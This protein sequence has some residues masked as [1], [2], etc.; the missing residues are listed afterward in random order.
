[1]R[2]VGYAES[3]LIVANSVIGALLFAAYM[4]DPVCINYHPD[5]RDVPDVAD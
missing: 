3:V 2:A 4:R 1:M 5:C